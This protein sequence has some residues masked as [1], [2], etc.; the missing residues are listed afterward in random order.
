MGLR[1]KL[2][3]L[4]YDRLMAGTE[5]AGLGEI[6]SRLLTEATGDVLE[7]GAGTGR[8]LAYY[9]TSVT[10]LTLT[11]PDPSMFR[12]LER[13]A[14]A[15]RRPTTALRA[16]AEDLPFDDAM[17]DTVVSTLVLCGVSDQPRAARE[18]RRVLKP[19][20]RL[21]LVEH[22]RSS[23]DDVARRQD[24]ISW[25]TRLALGCDVNRPTSQT[26]L[27]SGFAIDDLV[28]G[29]LPNSPSYVRPM[30]VGTATRSLDAHTSRS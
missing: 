7:V 23:E 28:D 6:R 2:F 18:I 9:G 13:T 27:R 19:G 21:L 20:G 24:R 5:K 10:S 3:A 14:R 17:F 8:N 16:P 26:L 29:E 30:I 4:V 11:E 15:A 12:R 1:S 22:V 25:L